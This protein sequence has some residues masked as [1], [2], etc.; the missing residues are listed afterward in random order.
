MTRH[1][2]TTAAVFLVAAGAGVGFVVTYWADGPHWLLGCCLAGALGGVGVALV[3][4]STVVAGG[5]EV[6]QERDRL[7]A[8]DDERTS[9]AVSIRRGTEPLGRRRVLLASAGA[10]AVAVVAAVLSPLRSLGPAPG[11]S[12]RTTPW[13]SGRRLVDGDGQPMRA[14]DLDPGGLATAFPEGAMEAG[15][16]PVVVVRLPRDRLTAAT[17]DGG[18]LDGVVAYSK[19]CTHAGCS[20][21][22]F[23]A[24]GRPPE[25]IYRLLCPC[26]QS[27]FDPLDGA[28]PAGGPAT[29]PLPQLPLSEDGDGYLVAGG[30]FPRPVGPAFWGWP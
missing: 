24:D 13:R 20:V 15:D 12:L 14:D 26:H 11:S 4:W 29:R 6:V 8:T 30:D 1:E 17:L 19:I 3:S 21:G 7:D 23:Q 18:A 16:G 27:L 10:A 5:A 9:V 25:T 22:L 28:R 2:W